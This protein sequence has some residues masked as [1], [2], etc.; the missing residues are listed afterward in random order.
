MSPTTV[1]P[2]M[3]AIPH[4]DRREALWTNLIAVEPSATQRVDV[5]F[6]AFGIA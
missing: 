1:K 2:P 6:T 4:A 3:S 5:R